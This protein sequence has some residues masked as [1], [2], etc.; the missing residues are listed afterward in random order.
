MELNFATNTTLTL[1]NQL[2]RSADDDAFAVDG[3]F[4]GATDSYSA[5]GQSVDNYHTFMIRDLAT[6]WRLHVWDCFVLFRRP[7]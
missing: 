6:N 2:G 5:S 7:E 3:T 4:T 1:L